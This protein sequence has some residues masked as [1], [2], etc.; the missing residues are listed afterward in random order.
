M[1][2]CY[3]VAEEISKSAWPFSKGEFLKHCLI[4]VCEVLCPDKS[5]HFQ[6]LSRNT[7]ADGITWYKLTGLTTDGAPAMCG[8]KSGLVGGMQKKMQRESCTGGLTLYHCIILFVFIQLKKK[9]LQ[10]CY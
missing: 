8:E 2:A 4:K 5:R 10:S 1:K 7:V 3:I 6:S 9:F